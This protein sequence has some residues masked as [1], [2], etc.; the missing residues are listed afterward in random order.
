M[1]ARACRRL[2]KASADPAHDPYIAS[3]HTIDT[4]TGELTSAQ[5]GQVAAAHEHLREVENDHSEVRAFR[6]NLL[7]W[8]GGL[9]L[10]SVVLATIVQHGFRYGLVGVVAGMLTTALAWRSLTHLSGPY[11]VSTAQALLK[12]SAGAAAA[13]VGVVL[14]R[15]GIISGLKPDATT[16]YGYAVVFGFSQQA[17]TQV[18]DSAA[19]NLGGS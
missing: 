15:S 17:F 14:V 11:S 19:K 12:V 2:A 1:C 3:L 7:L 18:V 10:G 6:N 16:A 4:T 8:T 9:A 13:L 5:R